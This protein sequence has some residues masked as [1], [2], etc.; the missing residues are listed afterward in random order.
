MCPLIS[1]VRRV[2][3]QVDLKNTDRYA[4]QAFSLPILKDTFSLV[5]LNLNQHI[6]D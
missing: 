2:S 6:L 3:I 4:N 1:H 5:E